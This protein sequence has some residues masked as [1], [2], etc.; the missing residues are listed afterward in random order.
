MFFFSEKELVWSPIAVFRTNF[1]LSI[2]KVVNI[3]GDTSA[4]DNSKP[5]TCASWSTH[6]FR[7]DEEPLPVEAE[8]DYA[9][10]AEHRDRAS[11]RAVLAFANATLGRWRR[12][13]RLRAREG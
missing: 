10:E 1:V 4:P 5:G 9:D 11:N 2:M 6:G 8:E 13:W 3:Q 12:R 7:R